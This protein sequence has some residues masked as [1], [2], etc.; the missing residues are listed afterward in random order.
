MVQDNIIPPSQFQDRPI[1]ALRKKN[2]PVPTPRIE[3]KEKKRTLNGFT[4]SIEI[5]LSSN[6]D[7]LIQLQNT[8]L[9]VSHFFWV[10]CWVMSKVSNLWRH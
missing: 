2:Q 4:K 6:R 10:I 1:E 7:P 8:R 5:S 3:T 9:A